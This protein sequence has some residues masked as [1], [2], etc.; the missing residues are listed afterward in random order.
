MTAPGV[1]TIVALT[2]ASAIDDPGRFESSKTVGAH[3]GLTPK[4]HQSGETDITGRI[5]R[6]G[7]AACSPPSTRRPMSF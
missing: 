6:S 7:T 2:Y 1:G 4:K 5:S 3:F